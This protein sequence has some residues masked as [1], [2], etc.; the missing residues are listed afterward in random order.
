[1]TQRLPRLLAAATLLVAAAT[2]VVAPASLGRA[3]DFP[4]NPNGYETTTLAPAPLYGLISE[5]RGGVFYHGYDTPEQ[6]SGVDLNAEVLSPRLWEI[7]GGYWDYLIPRLSLGGNLNTAG[8]TSDGYLALTWT[9]PIYRGLFAEISL[10][11]SL[12]DGHTEFVPPPGY[13]A[14]G[15]PLMFRESATLGYQFSQHWRVM[16]TAEPI[17]NDHLCARNAGITNF[18]GRLGYT[19]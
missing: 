8:R 7:N 19:F 12:N 3:A 9:A 13:S 5:V 15:C 17:S 16:A 14:V 10:G 4:L 2:L 11:G 1:M 6:G 18:G